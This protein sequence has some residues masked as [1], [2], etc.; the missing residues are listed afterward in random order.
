[1]PDIFHTFFGISGLLLLNHFE[2]NSK[3]NE[4]NRGLVEIM[5]PIDPTYALPVDLVKKL[6]LSTQIKK[7]V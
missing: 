6:G 4:I 7:A 3:D 2:K 5:K 1:M